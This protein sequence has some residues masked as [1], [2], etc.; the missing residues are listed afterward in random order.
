MLDLKIQP[1]DKPRD[2]F[3]FR[4][5]ICGSFYLVN[6]PFIF[7]FAAV[8]ISHRKGSMFNCMCKLENKAQYETC[9]QRENRKL[10]SHDSNPTM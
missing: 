3:I 5:K 1:P 8:Q 9:H 4:G 2:E 6:S 7:H 10:I